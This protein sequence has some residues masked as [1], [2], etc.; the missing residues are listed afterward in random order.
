ME[1]LNMKVE[2]FYDEKQEDLDIKL[3]KNEDES[4]TISSRKA[5]YV[6][7]KSL[8][9]VLKFDMIK[10]EKED[11]FDGSTVKTEEKTEQSGDLLEEGII[12]KFSDSSDDDLYSSDKNVMNVKTKTEFK[13]EIESTSESTHD[14]NT[15]VN[16]HCVSQCPGYH[17]IKQDY[18]TEVIKSS[19]PNNETGGETTLNGNNIKEFRTLDKLNQEQRIQPGEKPY[20]CVVDVKKCERNSPLE[21]LKR[22]HTGKMSYSCEIC[23][24]SLVSNRN[25]KSHQRIHTGEKPYSCTVCEKQ[26]RTKKC[27]K[28]SP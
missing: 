28:K 21:Q 27:F 14:T 16:I 24:K 23:G 1:V 2:P 12:S 26:F 18:Y 4:F 10:E 20:N 5:D 13:E 19:K 3:E 22:S 17:G 8:Q 15:S 6:E 25:L 7:E 9:T 11:N